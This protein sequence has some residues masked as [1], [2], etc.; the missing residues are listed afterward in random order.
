MGFI[1][2]LSFPASHRCLTT[3]QWIPHQ[4]YPS[5][6]Q[7]HLN[8]WQTASSQALRGS[9]S[10][11][12]RSFLPLPSRT[13]PSK[14]HISSIPSRPSLF[15]GQDSCHW[16]CLFIFQQV[17]ECS[18]TSSSHT[19]SMT[20]AHSRVSR[21]C[22]YKVHIV[23]PRPGSLSVWDAEPVWLNCEGC[24]SPWDWRGQWLGLIPRVCPLESCL[25]SAHVLSSSLWQG[26]V[27]LWFTW[28][29]TCIIILEEDGYRVLYIASPQNTVQGQH[30]SWRE[31]LAFNEY[32]EIDVLDRKC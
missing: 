21:G 10:V 27:F 22:V 16:W 1:S 13:L 26:P 9:S 18:K 7:W 19:V 2:G 24:K 15:C 32:C 31:H 8:F 17:L 28:R 23:S 25:Y 29:K 12:H 3:A 5:C 6:W 11:A 30:L 14:I 4:T 20:L